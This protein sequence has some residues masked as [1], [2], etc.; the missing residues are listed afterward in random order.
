MAKKQQS[1]SQG[2]LKA[3]DLIKQLD[4]YVKAIHDK[5]I[6]VVYFNHDKLEF[7]KRGISGYNV[8][9]RTVIAMTVGSEANAIEVQDIYLS[10]NRL[11][12]I[13][14]V[15]KCD[16]KDI[17]KD[18][19]VYAYLTK[20]NEFVCSDS[21]KTKKLNFKDKNNSGLDIYYNE[22][23][24]NGEYPKYVIAEYENQYAICDECK[25]LLLDPLDFAK[26]DDRSLCLDCIHKLR[27]EDKVDPNHYKLMKLHEIEKQM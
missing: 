6:K 24:K 12:P 18:G 15:A 7:I 1:K 11:E 26:V 27:K 2:I 4:G 17:F 3:E 23:Y 8:E 5:D 13:G 16:I 14:N 21:S 9:T 25:K 10:S 20:D 22:N 19:N